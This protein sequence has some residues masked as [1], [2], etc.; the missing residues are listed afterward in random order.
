M[1]STLGN[2]GNWFT[3]DD[4][5]ATTSS[6]SNPYAFT[7]RRLDDETMLMHFRRRPY[8]TDDG[9]FISRDPQG[10]I[11]GVSLYLAYFA[12]AG[13]DPGPPRELEKSDRDAARRRRD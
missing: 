1:G 7:G 8:R 2:D 12:P 13:T 5:T 3:S 9:I 11:D 4:D 10:Y 6:I